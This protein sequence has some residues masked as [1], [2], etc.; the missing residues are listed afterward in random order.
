MKGAVMANKQSKGIYAIILILSGL[1]FNYGFTVI[2]ASVRIHI[3]NISHV[4]WNS[5]K[6]DIK[7]TFQLGLKDGD[8]SEEL[9]NNYVDCMADR[10]IAFLNNTSCSYKYNPVITQKEDHL[11]DQDD[12]VEKSGYTKE[13]D[14][15]ASSCAETAAKKFAH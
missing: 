7:K 15:I 6:G 12:C 14:V 3:D 11:R 8:F 1:L 5:A 9:K 13:L 2:M 10:A 4:G